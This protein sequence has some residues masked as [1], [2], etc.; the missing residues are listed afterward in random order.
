[1]ELNF[2]QSKDSYLFQYFTSNPVSILF[3]IYWEHGDK[4]SLL[5]KSVCHAR[6]K[7]QAIDYIYYFHHTFC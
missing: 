3:H 2:K 1:M 5:Y 7:E 6:I 4:S